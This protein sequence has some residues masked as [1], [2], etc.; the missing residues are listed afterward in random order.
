MV[1]LTTIARGWASSSRASRR[2]PRTSGNPKRGEVVAGDERALRGRDLR[3]VFG[4]S[5]DRERAERRAR[6]RLTRGERHRFGEG[7]QSAEQVTEHTRACL[8]REIRALRRVVRLREPH[9]C[10]G[11]AARGSKPGS[12]RCRCQKLRTRR[13]PDTS[14][15]TAMAHSSMMSARRTRACPRPG[16][17][18]PRP[19]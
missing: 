14:S 5:F 6:H 18:A 7:P 19:A 1:S 17:G 3:R 15:T 13:A 2:R 12:T 4:P 11:H 10:R 9:P 16:A 8:L